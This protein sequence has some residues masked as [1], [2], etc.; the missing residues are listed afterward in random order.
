MSELQLNSTL[1]LQPLI[2]ELSVP[3][4]LILLAAFFI[5]DKEQMDAN[6]RKDVVARLDPSLYKLEGESL[7][8]YK[9]E[10][11]IADEELLKEHILTVQ[12]KAFEV[13]TDALYSS[14]SRSFSDS[15]MRGKVFN[16]TC[17]RIF[18]FLK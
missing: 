10:T 12:R 4:S 8:F 13:S 17:I 16:Y 3:I 11:G 2:L 15:Q 18:D 9:R 1:S 6:A 5:L 7:D 14:F